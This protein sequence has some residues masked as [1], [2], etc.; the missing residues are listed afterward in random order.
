MKLEET[1][2]EVL[3]HIIANLVLDEDAYTCINLQSDNES[4]QCIRFVKTLSYKPVPKAA[5]W[6]NAEGSLKSH[7][8]R[9]REDGLK[10]MTSEK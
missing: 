9:R 5:H 6:E 8:E 7:K 4:K 1:P 2:D 10:K 3:D